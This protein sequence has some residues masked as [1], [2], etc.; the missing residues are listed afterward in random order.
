MLA[1]EAAE[2][3]EEG[4]HRKR[5]LIGYGRANREIPKDV[6]NKIVMLQDEAGASRRVS[7]L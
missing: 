2:V 5:D 3:E 1:L 4:L 6:G 7:S